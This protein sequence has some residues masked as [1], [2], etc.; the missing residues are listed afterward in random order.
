MRSAAVGGQLLGD[1]RLQPEDVLDVLAGQR[2]HH[3]TA[4]RLELDHALAAQFQQRL[5]HRG[6]ADAELG[7]GLVEPDERPWPQRAGHD[8]RPQVA[9][10]LVGQLRPAQRNRRPAAGNRVR[11]SPGEIIGLV[12]VV[13]ETIV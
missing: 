6:G 9:R 7:R 13:A 11:R 4:V 12:F 3:V 1:R 8:R 2:Q 5:A 10:D